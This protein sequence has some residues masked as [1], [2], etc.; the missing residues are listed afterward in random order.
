MAHS[1][2]EYL[3]RQAPPSVRRLHGIVRRSL[4]GTHPGEV[5][6]GDDYIQSQDETYQKIYDPWNSEG[7]P[8]QELLFRHY[9]LV[10]A[11]LDK[12]DSK[13][14]EVGCGLGALTQMLWAAGFRVT[15]L[16]ASAT[17]VNRAN[18]LRPEV[19]FVVGDVRLWAPPDSQPY[20]AVL[21]M[22]VLHRLDRSDQ[23]QALRNVEKM[24]RPGGKV[25]VNYGHD[26]Y[27]NREATSVYPGLEEVI[28]S[29]FVL[30]S[31]VTHKTV[32][33]ENGEELAN[34]VYVAKKL[35]AQ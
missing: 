30:F 10:S 1:I 18:Q 22:E 32:D 5:L 24:L 21:L 3:Y 27:L 7:G 34:R 11:L 19:D 29:V 6:L 8:R 14:L 17:A 23:L 4:S 20:D 33:L 12:R 13:V 16:D 2:R 31:E 25:I 15:G 28:S 26:N 9:S 35:P